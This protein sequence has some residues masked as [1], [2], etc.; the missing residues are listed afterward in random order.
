MVLRQ[1]TDD[2]IMR[3]RK[4]SIYVPDNWGKKRT[5]SKYLILIAFPRNK[6]CLESASLL[7]YTFSACLANL[8]VI[9]VGF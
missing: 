8:Y 3:R 2:S 9:S 1:A 7:G 5:H 4:D 6:K